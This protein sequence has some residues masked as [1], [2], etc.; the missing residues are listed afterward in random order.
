MMK[1]SAFGWG[2]KRFARLL[3]LVLVILMFCS[4]VPVGALAADDMEQPTGDSIAGL[5]AGA[6]AESDP[7]L[8]EV[9]YEPP[10]QEEPAPAQEEPAA[11]PEDPD[12]A[13]ADPAEEP[14]DPA[15]ED[16]DL[17]PDAGE[18]PTGDNI[19]PVE[20]GEMEDVE[21]LTEE[22]AP[23]SETMMDL[24]EDYK[25]PLHFEADCNG[26]TVIVDAPEGTLPFGTG[27]R[28]APVWDN[29]VLQTIGDEVGADARQV[30]AVDISFRYQDEEIEPDG[31]IFVTLKSQVIEASTDA[32]VVHMDN[33]GNTQVVDQYANPASD[34]L[35]FVADSF[36][37]YAIVDG[38]ETVTYRRTYKFEDIDG[39]DTY[40]AYYFYN[41]SGD[42]VDEQIIKNGD[43]LETVPEP[44]HSGKIFE[45][46]YVWENGAFGDKVEF[47]T[48]LSDIAA[49]ETVTVRAKY[50]NVYYVNFHEKAQGESPD[51]ILTTKVTDAEGN[52]TISDVLA[53]Q[54]DESHLFHG[55]IY[56]GTETSVYNDQH[57]LQPTSL[58]VTG[59]ADLYPA[60]EEAFW[61]RFV[62]GETGSR[63]SYVP[64]KFVRANG[65]PLTNLPVPTRP[66]YSFIGWSTGEM[67]DGHIAYYEGGL[68][69]DNT[70]KVTNPE[71]GLAL[72]EETTLYGMWV[73]NNEASY[74]VIIWRQKV[75]DDKN[76]ADSAKTYDYVTSYTTTGVTGTEPTA[77]EDE[78]HEG[79]DY[80][81]FHYAHTESSTTTIQPDGSTVVNV[82]YDRDL[83]TINFYYQRNHAPEGAGGDNWVYT[84]TTDNSGTQYG[85]DE[86]GN[87]VQLTSGT[88]Y[89]TTYDY[90]W[91]GTTN[92]YTGTF[93]TQ[94]GNGYAESQYSGS[95]LPPITDNTQ[96]YGA[97]VDWI[98]FIPIVSYNPIERHTTQTPRTVWYLNGQPYTGTRY[99]RTQSTGNWVVVTWTGLYG[100]SFGQNSYSWPNSYKWNESS[101]GGGTNQTLLTGFTKS[102]NPYNLYD[103]GLTGS[104]QYRHYKQTLDGGYAETEG[105]YEIAASTLSNPNLTTENKFTG[106]T[107]S[108]Y[109][110][111]REGFSSSGGNHSAVT[112]TRI[113]SRESG[114][115]VYI[116]HTR[117]KWRIDYQVPNQAGT[118]FEVAYTTG[119][120]SIYF[121]AP[122]NDYNLTLAQAG[123]P[124]REH[125][126]FKGWYADETLT[127]PFNFSTTMPNANVAV[128]AKFEKVSYQIIIDP[129]GGIIT[130]EI[131]ATYFWKHYQET[132]DRYEISRTYIEDPNGD[133]KYVY[134]DG[135]NDPEGDITVRTATYELAEAGYTGKRY[136][137][138]DPDNDLTYVLVGW[139][140]VDAQGNLSADPYD[141]G[142]QVEGPV[143]IRAV[144][145]MDGSFRLVYNPT[146]DAEDENGDTVQ[147]SGTFS[148]AS[149]DAEYA[150]QAQIVMQPGPT[151]VTP[152]FVF[153]G[154]EI[155]DAEWNT[156]DNNGGSYYKPG[157]KLTLDAAAWAHNKVVRI[158][159]HYTH[160]DHSD[161]PTM[162][163]TLI[164]DAN[165]GTTTVTSGERDHE[166]RHVDDAGDKII[167]TVNSGKTQVTYYPMYV[168]EKFDLD[169]VSDKFTREKYVLA[170]W[171]H[172]KAAADNGEVEFET[173]TVV[174]ADNL[175]DTANTLYAVWQRVYTV[176][177]R[178]LVTGN[179][180]DVNRSFTITVT[181]D[182]PITYHDAVVAA[183]T[184]T[185]L[186]LKSGDTSDD[187]TK[188]PENTTFTVTETAVQGYGV[189][190][191]YF[192]TDNTIEPTSFGATAP[193]NFEITADGTFVVT[194]NKDVTVDTAVSLDSLPFIL[195]ITLTVLSSAAMLV[196]YKRRRGNER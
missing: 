47:E 85:V 39:S 176:N 76:A 89:D 136:R 12:P 79:G 48:A 187:F 44:F 164:L 98:F 144:W 124:E 30:T 143:T 50:S 96:Y 194:N 113:T 178:K 190:Y 90:V 159:A 149:P 5:A 138:I 131:G 6:G 33:Y 166:A 139:Y 150:D 58:T 184:E 53:P 26:L 28:V 154:W 106:F 128:Y 127:T 24:V 10:A 72:T 23:A 18:T 167:V 161:D 134:V 115:P 103:Q 17:P 61:L 31:Y 87:Y 55:W 56:N 60:F 97:E 78:E 19:V 189:S 110:T 8:E 165:G 174:G 148:Q 180:G 82:Y 92:R 14:E 160:V 46:W 117:N 36:S 84:P 118:G 183:G 11:E 22:N 67:V 125:Y 171:N 175:P 64:A 42:Y 34:E 147:V 54:P 108:T 193:S 158:R 95:N 111:N 71:S 142:A 45:G 43:E 168:N 129:D 75:S 13:P 185:I 172:D 177:V 186:T 156:L 157:D 105:N 146:A 100:Q 122:L 155:V 120:N 135:K 86:S 107:V 93:Y 81:G 133:Y 88:E 27:M 4:L 68:V 123:I 130:P 195:I 1:G 192:P 51:V 181:A 162:V 83:M 25:P 152:N 29:E 41:K 63:A 151:D 170:G 140:Q 191:S 141:F 21:A 57:Q 15:D 109:S 9:S 49:D 3:S 80:A 32:Q 59:N 37:V 77:S 38:G 65:D 16:D 70:G 132:F 104:N 179:M 112:G 99:T 35:S 119:N 137:P 145:R 121:E 173:N 169:E 153:D 52:L 196:S 163:T 62:S 40:A 126:E 102:E 66:G 182:K 74:S 7:T 20:E 69:T 116:Y 73:P 101:N 91:R 188:I 114:F 2:S 94:V